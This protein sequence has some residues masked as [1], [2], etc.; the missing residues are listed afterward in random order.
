M[1]QSRIAA[2]FLALVL[3]GLGLVAGVVI[4]RRWL[5]SAEAEA[6]TAPRMRG[7]PV[8]VL[9]A[10]FDERLGLSPEQ[11]DEMAEVLSKARAE[12]LKLR[13]RLRP[14]LEAVWKRSRKSIHA[15]LTPEQTA[16]YDRLVE[17]EFSRAPGKRR[18]RDPAEIFRVL[19]LNSDGHVTREE[20]EKSDVR[21]ARRLLE[22]FDELDTDKDGGLAKEELAAGFPL[23]GRW[24]R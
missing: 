13:G 16:E 1:M 6:T 9:V 3:V 19:D 5:A 18:R 11:S 7:M 8:E 14:E 24:N 4:E 20:C 22:Q 23:R 21:P 17:R 2:A 15:I 10:R 12:V